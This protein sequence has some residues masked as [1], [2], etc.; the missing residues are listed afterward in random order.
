MFVWWY[1]KTWKNHERNNDVNTSFRHFIF[2]L[3]PNADFEPYAVTILKRPNGKS[4]GNWM[5]ASLIPKWIKVYVIFPYFKSR[6]SST[7]LLFFP[8][9][10]FFHPSE[11]FSS[12][13]SLSLSLSLHLSLSLFLYH[14]YFSNIPIFVSICCNQEVEAESLLTLPKYI[15]LFHVLRL[16]LQWTF[17]LRVRKKNIFTTSTILR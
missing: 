2:Y 13:L 17:I 16:Y 1:N 9:S 6:V 8:S 10:L 5:N 12:S 4:P 11:L 15:V 7:L 14:F 3:W